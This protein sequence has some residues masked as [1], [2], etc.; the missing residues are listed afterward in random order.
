MSRNADLARRFGS[1]LYVYDL[2]RVTAARRDLFAALPDGVALYFSFKAN[3]HPEI[4]RALRVAENGA[5]D[6]RVCRAEV[7]ST[8]ELAAAMD[9]GFDAADVLY[10][11]PGKTNGEL[12]AAIATGVRVFSVESLSDLRH[13]GAAATGHGVTVDCLLRVNSAS[14]SSSTSIRMTGT[15]SQFGLDSET[16]P[17]ILAELRDVPG[18]RLAGMH[19]FSLSNA[20]DE[21]SLIA[22]FRHTISV[23][24]DLHRR[25][26]LPVRLLDI[27]GGFAAPYLVPGD[28][29]VYPGLRSALAATLD[30]HFPDWRTGTP[31][32]A[33]ES[34]RH[35]VGDGGQLVCTV[36]NVKES[37]GQRFV[38][39]DAGI[40]IL[41]GMSG[42][43]RLL[44]VT[45]GFD[46]EAMAGEV[47]LGRLE[48]ANL[49]GPLCTPGDILGRGV[50]AP[51]LSP[52]DVVTIPNAGAYGVTASL[53]M[54]LGRPAPVEVILRGDEVVSASRI[55][56]HRKYE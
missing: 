42:L 54:F 31:E 52:G 37:R 18:T 14:T 44:P 45:V 32:V 12:T 5:G 53:L 41:G 9:A 47:D 30:E 23:A 16:L 1:P 7:S 10:T 4:A 2:D 39:L 13:V 28:R 17:E 15:P 51:A 3:P 11:G 40:N 50:P 29:P 8:G 43:G 34:G 6:G 19:L 56:F 27:G 21:A 25:L 24:A 48:T 35:L 33:C 36:V 26:G 49:V 20:Q 38:I 55:E 46:E 22:E